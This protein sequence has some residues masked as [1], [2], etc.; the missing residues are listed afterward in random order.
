M[1]KKAIW[2]IVLIAIVGVLIYGAV[3]RTLAKTVDS[4]TGSESASLAANHSQTTEVASGQGWDR[5]QS[6]KAVAESDQVQNNAEQGRQGQNTA[7]ET[8]QGQGN[9]R[10]QNRQTEQNSAGVGEA[11]QAGQGY[12]RQGQN[13]GRAQNRQSEQAGA[14]NAEAVHT[15]MV[16]QTVQGEV[17]SLAPDA[18]IVE[19]TSGT[20]VFVA[21]RPWSYAQESGFVVE[22]GDEVTLNGFEENGEFK[23]GELT[24][25]AGGQLVQIRE[26]SGRPLWAGG[27]QG[28]SR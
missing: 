20:S 12:G 17:V 3:N 7:S 15:D 19:T 25:D 13:K 14:G 6:E 27:G 9:G 8:W 5:G 11:E 21:G 18:M 22:L 4:N 10:G 16:W 24:N 2:S 28:R 26:Y 1:L 23:V